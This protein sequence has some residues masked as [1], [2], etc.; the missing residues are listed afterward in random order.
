[1]VVRGRTTSNQRLLTAVF[2]VAAYAV[3]IAGA[4]ATGIA[5]DIALLALGVAVGVYI[6][7]LRSDSR[8]LRSTVDELRAQQ[9]ERAELVSD[10]ERARRTDSVT[11][12]GN[13]QHL[14]AALPRLVTEAGSS[15]SS[16]VVLVLEL[17]GLT[18][19]RDLH[20][21]ELGDRVLKQLAASWQCHMRM[22]DVLVRV[23]VG[24]FVAVLPACSPANAHRVAERLAAATPPD[25][26]C[27]VGVASW[28]GSERSEQLLWRAEAATRAACGR[29]T[30]VL[31]AD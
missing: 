25:L 20:G 12:L 11:G 27:S 28:D 23:T 13:R 4:L 22:N 24:E 16:L 5:A 9:F 31:V 26:G 15:M 7:R 3:L 18:H 1:M 30:A 10:L 6:D 29:G 17:D 19:Y 21:E 2:A 8:R 14:D